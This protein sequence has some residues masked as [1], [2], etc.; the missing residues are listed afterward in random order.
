MDITDWSLLTQ[1]SCTIDSQFLRTPQH[2]FFKGYRLAQFGSHELSQFPCLRQ[3]QY[4]EARIYMESAAVL[5]HVE[6]PFWLSVIYAG[7][8]GK[9]QFSQLWLAI[10]CKLGDECALIA[11]VGSKSVFGYTVAA[12]A[13][14]YANFIRESGALHK[15]DRLVSLEQIETAMGLWN[16]INAAEE[17]R[18]YI[19]IHTIKLADNCEIVQNLQQGST[20]SLLRYEAMLS[21]NDTHKF[22]VKEGVEENG[23][24]TRAP[25]YLLM[26]GRR[27]LGG[28]VEP[29]QHK[30]Q[31]IVD[32]EKEVNNTAIRYL[33]T[34]AVLGQKEAPS[35]LACIYVQDCLINNASTNNKLTVATWLAIACELEDESALAEQAEQQLIFDP[36]IK[37]LAE[38]YANFMRLSADIHQDYKGVSLEHIELVTW[39][40]NMVD[41]Q[42]RFNLTPHT[43]E[44]ACDD[45]KIY[46][47]IMTAV[48]NT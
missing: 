11:S 16:R 15:L 4:Y 22:M 1:D 7:T 2:L 14:L 29:D 9:E 21:F 42:H 6:A 18:C 19:G 41:D 46:E 37:E 38:L 28:L 25:S 5:G 27:L 12:S 36:E 33:E 24:F 32:F 23:N 39:A 45:G 47:D 17:Y 13:E 34:A 40:W 26:C 20:K 35:L 48:E 8:S 3:K 10:G 43:L 44:L 31:N 30:R